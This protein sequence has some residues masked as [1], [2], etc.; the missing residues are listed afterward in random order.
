MIDLKNSKNQRVCLAV[1]CENIPKRDYFTKRNPM[2]VVYENEEE[3][4]RSEFYPNEPNPVFMKR[5]EFFY[6]PDEVQNITIK[7][8]DHCFHSKILTDQPFVG[9]I[10]FPLS[11]LFSQPTLTINKKLEHINLQPENPE[12]KCT[13]I[14]WFVKN[15]KQ[16]FNTKVIGTNLDKKDAFGKSDPYLIFYSKKAD[17]LIWFPVYQTEILMKTLNPIWEPISI[18][19]H[20]FV[21]GEM[22]NII[23]IECYDW[24][25]SGKPDFIGEGEFNV[26]ELLQKDKFELSLIEPKKKEKKKNYQ[27]SG[28]LT[29]TNSIVIEEPT[30]QTL[31]K[32]GHSISIYVTIDFS[33]AN[34]KR[35]EENSFH[36]FDK[37]KGIISLH[38]KAIRNCLSSVQDWLIDDPIYTYG[39]G[40]K[41]TKGNQD[42]FSLNGKENAGIQ[43][44]ESILM[45]YE[46]ALNDEKNFKQVYSRSIFPCLDHVIEE[47]KK[48]SQQDPM[49]YFVIVMFVRTNIK[50]R[51]ETYLKIIEASK[52]PISIIFVCVGIRSMQLKGKKVGCFGPFVGLDYEYLRMPLKK[53]IPKRDIVNTVVF[54]SHLELDHEKIFDRTFQKVPDQMVEF[55]KQFNK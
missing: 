48:K 3:I 13:V 7:V 10:N 43:G 11:E 18:R 49:K 54:E 50:Q 36:Y 52:L 41:T 47:I 27:N 2:V 28:V 31:L 1:Y 14:G 8:L 26:Q 19:I 38:Q 23:K 21:G 35:K 33:I 20:K 24:N 25:K 44:I 39:Y 6:N 5:F 15:E 16:C 40:A 42:C 34:F 9:L 46:T 51:E 37:E 22:P 45:E 17:D 53:Q 4:G 30:F 29:F 32:E 12:P 55:Y